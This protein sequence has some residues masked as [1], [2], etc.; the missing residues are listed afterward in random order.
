MFRDPTLDGELLCDF[1]ALYATCYLADALFDEKCVIPLF[2]TLPV[3]TRAV[4][5]VSQ[6][7]QGHEEQFWN[8]RTGPLCIGCYSDY[9]K[10]KPAAQEDGKTS[11]TQD[12]A[13]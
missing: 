1:D 6:F 11:K 10:K 12:C 3:F 9:T 4:D 7:S 13:K 5:P 2:D 8:E